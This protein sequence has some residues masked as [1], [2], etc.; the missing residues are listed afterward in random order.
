MVRQLVEGVNAKMDKALEHLREELGSLRTGRATTGLVDGMSVEV[1]GQMMPI[2]QLASIN[3]PDARTIAIS[4]WD[5]NSMA[6]IEKAIRE[7]QTL[8]LNPSNDG[9]VIRL[10]IPP[11]TEDRRR[12]IVKQLGTK[13][14]EC[15]IALRNARHDVLDEAKKLEKDKQITQ[16]DLKF[17]EAELNKKIDVYKEKIEEIRLA[18]E[19]EIMEV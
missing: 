4:P 6:S 12:E 19:K 7:N 10:N 9:S 3:T 5:R 8:G 1:Y 18:K 11:M 2:K 13:V 16:D 14:E 17:A 15:N